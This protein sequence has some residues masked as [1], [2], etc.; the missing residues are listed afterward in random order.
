MRT[1]QEVRESMYELVRTGSPC[2]KLRRNGRWEIQDL[3]VAG[4]A[5]AHVWLDNIS[6]DNKA[7]IIQLVAS[8]PWERA[9][10]FVSKM[11]AETT[12]HVSLT[13]GLHAVV[14][15]VLPFLWK[16]WEQHNHLQ[17]WETIHRVERRGISELFTTMTGAV[18]EV[19]NLN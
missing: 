4:S 9:F 15:S 5:V 7:R 1:G 11:V 14:E 19:I 6:A 17:M 12:F 10:E 3:G 16:K 18:Y 8:N 13:P 2:K